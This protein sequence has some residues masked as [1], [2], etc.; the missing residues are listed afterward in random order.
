MTRVLTYSL[1]F[2]NIEIKS[3]FDRTMAC[4]NKF[5]RFEQK[6]SSIRSKATLLQNF[7]GSIRV[8]N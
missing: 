1:K 7:I 2:L 5:Q 3:L 8:T 4:F 6:N